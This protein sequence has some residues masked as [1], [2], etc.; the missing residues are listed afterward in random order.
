LL[1]N[2]LHIQIIKLGIIIIKEAL[3]VRPR[4][5]KKPQQSCILEAV[6]N[7]KLPKRRR[8]RSITA[9]NAKENSGTYTIYC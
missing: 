2:V 3:P 1:V 4:S 9:T 7:K 8:N 5:N 6:S